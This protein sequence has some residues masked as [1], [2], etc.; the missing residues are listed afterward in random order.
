M[1]PI[2]TLRHE[3]DII[4]LVLRGVERGAGSLAAT[5]DADPDWLDTIVDLVR[6][7]ADRCHHGKEERHLFPRLEQRGV[8][9]EGGPIGVMLR[10]HERGRAFIRAVADAAAGARAR[11]T[12]A[13]AAASENL[14]GYVELLRSHI[15]KENDVLF[16]M[17]DRVLTEADQRELAEA[18]ERVE[19]EEMGEGVHERYHELAHRLA[20]H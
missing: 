5:L 8:P 18:F 1:G 4:L 7:F 20:E 6:N 15:A 19:A 2:A 17:A 9:K 3:H 12:E 13:F 14:L 16:P 11:E 10:E